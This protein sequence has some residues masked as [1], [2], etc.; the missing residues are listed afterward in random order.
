MKSITV[1]L[2][3][4]G[5]ALNRDTK[6][7]QN[8]LSVKRL[9]RPTGEH[10]FISKPAIRHYLFETLMRMGWREARVSAEGKSDKQ[11]IQFDL[12]QDNIMTSEELDVFGYM[13]TP[14]KTDQEKGGSFT[15]KSPL[16]ITKAV[17]L[18]P[19]LGD[20]AFYANHHMVQ[21]AR[22]EGAD[23]QPNPY[24]KEEHLSFYKV[25]FTLDGARLGEDVWVLPKE[26]EADGDDLLLHIHG[27]R[28]TSLK[29]QA[30]DLQN[31]EARLEHGVLRWES[32]DGDKRWKVT[33]SLA[34]E[35]KRR[36]IRDVLEALR[37]GLIAQS[38]GEVNPLT[39]VF[40]LAAPVRVPSPI[41]HPKIDLLWEQKRLLIRGVRDAVANGW[42]EDPVYLYV[43]ERLE[44]DLPD[45][46][47]VR[48]YTDRGS[49]E[50]WET[51]LNEVLKT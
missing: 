46:D 22:G 40:F 12:S 4:E 17:S 38:S 33:F 2:I 44:T 23:A 5:S 8:T 3:F 35:E 18:E 42:R 19:Y 27:N 10:T 13:F 49:R 39:P 1:T 11:V 32:L 47:D 6:V 31:Q 15:R 36:R 24:G 25:S 28:T 26:P 51:W 37:N 43:S 50:H 14:E 16:G 7:D 41:F 48:V 34:P 29:T 21:R 30:I 9:T 20:L 45:Q